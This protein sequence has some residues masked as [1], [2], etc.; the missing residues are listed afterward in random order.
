MSYSELPFFDFQVRGQRLDGSGV[1]FGRAGS[2]GPVEREVL[3]GFMRDWQARDP[4]KRMGVIPVEHPSLFDDEESH[5]VEAL[6]GDRLLRF[7]EEEDGL[8]LGKSA[9]MVEQHVE[10][11]KGVMK[12]E[13][14][15]AFR[16]LAAEQG[17]A[18]E[19][20]LDGPWRA[21]LCRVR[22]HGRVEKSVELFVGYGVWKEDASGLVIPDG[23][24][25]HKLS[26]KYLVLGRPVARIDG[27]DGEDAG[28]GTTKV[29][30]DLDQILEESRA[31]QEVL[32][33]TSKDPSWEE[34]VDMYG[35][36][37]VDNVGIFL[38]TAWP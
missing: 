28:D 1:Y 5:Q 12:P 36:E 15:E 14:E 32:R 33:E 29:A 6:F 31:L 9:S 4:Y 18:F 30:V 10:R 27:L 24:K 26:R 35:D 37:I 21:Y 8:V 7:E 13:D 23:Y 34:M 3:A 19:G 38:R 22:R 17:V 20:L 25:L 11:I 2:V 16:A